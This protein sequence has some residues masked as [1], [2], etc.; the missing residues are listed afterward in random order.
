[1]KENLHKI[2]YTMRHKAAFLKV[3][4]RLCGRNTLRGWLHDLDKLLLYL[5]LPTGLAHSI[6]VK[7]S[8]H[9][10]RART[11]EDYVQMVVDWECARFTKPDKPLNAVETMEKFY[12]HLKGKVKPVLL[13]LGLLKD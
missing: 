7:R 9:H 10:E 2:L 6:H 13:E 11:H 5:F 3:E 8:R 1:M 4:K 12:P